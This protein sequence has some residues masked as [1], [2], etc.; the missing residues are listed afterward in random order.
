MPV[1]AAV[2]ASTLQRRGR[3]VIRPRFYL[4]ALD[5]PEP[6]ALAIAVVLTA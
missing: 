4:L 6:V 1:P 3:G 2:D 5:E